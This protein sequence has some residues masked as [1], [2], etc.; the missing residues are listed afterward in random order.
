M[1]YR[2]EQMSAA[3]ST[4]P[5][6][7]RRPTLLVGLLVGALLTAACG[8][9]WSDDERAAVYA[10]ANGTASGSSSDRADGGG[11]AGTGSAVAGGPVA[12][13]GGSVVATTGGTASEG[14]TGT[15]TA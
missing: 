9:R 15:A 3:S 8:A 10:R 14:S 13:D 5:R 2:G 1:A 12:T 6:K 7:V 4:A 11:G